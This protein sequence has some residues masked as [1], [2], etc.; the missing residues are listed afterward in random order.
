MLTIPAGTS[1]GVYRILAVANST[2]VVVEGSSLNNTGSSAPVIVGPDLV[3]T[4]AGVAPTTVAP[5]GTVAVTNTVKNQGA[6]S[7]G[8]ASLVG[9]FLSSDTA[10]DGADVAIGV[11]RTVPILAGG[12]I[13]TATTSVVIPSSTAPGTYRVLVVAD[14]T[15]AVTE[16]NETN[17]VLAS[18]PITVTRPDLV[19]STVT[20]PAAV[21]AGM[22]FAVTNTIKNN[23]GVLAP[24]PFSV[25]FFLSTDTTFDGSDI[26]LGATRTVAS[27]GPNAVSTATT[28][29][30][31][32]AGTPLGVYR[33][34]AVADSTGAVVE[35]N[36][37]NNVGVSGP[38]ILGPDLVIT[39]ATMPTSV[40][41]GTPVTV[42]FTVKNQ[43]GATTGT[44]FDVGFTVVQVA[45]PDVD[46]PI[47]PTRT[48]IPALAPGA[49]ASL[50]AVL[51][52]PTSL[53]PSTTYQIRVTGDVNGAIGE[54]N[55]GNNDRL[56][57]S[58]VIVLPDLLMTSFTPPAALIAGRTLNVA[59]A[60]KNNASAPAT[61]APFQVGLYVSAD[62]TIDPGADTLLG[63]RA[64]TSLGPLATSSVPISITVP[65]TMGDFF[66][67][68]VADRLGSVAEFDENN[69]TTVKPI[70]I[71]PDLV[72]TN[73]IANITFNISGGP[74]C[75][76]TILGSGTTSETIASQTGGT[77]SG[78]RLVFADNQGGTNTV[79]FSGSVNGSGAMAGTMSVSRVGGGG[80]TGSGTL[81]GTAAVGSPTLGALTLDFTGT[82]TIA[83]FGTCGLTAHV[84]YP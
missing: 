76:G 81:T 39:A 57:N 23:T 82:M 10:F 59:N 42:T 74:T 53:V 7:T 44:T 48:A 83:G 73:V 67:G 27:L 52:V 79:T 37:L 62:N 3:V 54:A 1:A 40:S 35:A 12:G 78:G 38:V 47:G 8:A 25:A 68:A 5:G 33:I 60:V 31:I 34:L 80:G 45:P 20:A 50:S 64:L 4:A 11:S 2:G 14:V 46:I 70:A 51:T 17:N 71:V 69:N 55:E 56:T 43:G 77:F 26:P 41:P 58:F 15:S 63:S 16:G 84:T 36:D 22:P 72:R 65:T 18:V 75:G 19:V 61:A 28:M 21:S 32:P 24:G 49:T 13:S 6:T 66:L 30:T 29:L 9:F